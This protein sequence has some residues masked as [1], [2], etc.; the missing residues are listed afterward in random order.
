MYYH[1][2]LRKGIIDPAD[3]L[4]LSS[5]IGCLLASRLKNYLSEEEAMERLKSSIIKKS[6]LTVEEKLSLNKKEKLK[7]ISKKIRKNPKLV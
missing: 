3:I 4:L 2:I 5:I 7:K 1:K 6:E